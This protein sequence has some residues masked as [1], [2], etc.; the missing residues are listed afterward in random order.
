VGVGAV[1]RLRWAEPFLH[2]H[3]GT[4]GTIR[5]VEQRGSGANLQRW[6]LV[7]F[8]SAASQPCLWGRFRFEELEL[9]T[10]AP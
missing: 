7:E 5:A 3:A 6:Y 1:V 9:L 4:V 2:L 10:P 8:P